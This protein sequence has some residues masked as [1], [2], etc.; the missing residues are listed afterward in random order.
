MKHP[1]SH[2]LQLIRPPDGMT[3]EE[4][5]I[6]RELGNA[7]VYSIYSRLPT[8]RMKAIVA[9]HFECGYTQ[10]DVAEIFGVTQ[11]QIYLDILNIRKVLTGEKYKPQRQVSNVGI[12]DVMAML[13]TMIQP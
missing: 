10:E 6:E 9:L 7:V 1:M 8:T 2:R 3:P 13:T 11:E 12:E 5:E 4:K